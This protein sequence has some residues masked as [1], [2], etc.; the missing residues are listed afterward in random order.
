MHRSGRGDKTAFPSIHVDKCEKRQPAYAA[1][2]AS[3]F[4]PEAARRSP[5][6]DVDVDSEVHGLVLNRHRFCVVGVVVC[7]GGGW[8]EGLLEWGW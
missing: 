5:D 4:S 8:F 6:E 7:G 2:A 3:S 1:A